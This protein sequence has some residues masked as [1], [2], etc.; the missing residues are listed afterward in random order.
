MKVI[1]EIPDDTQFID[2][3]LRDIK[4]T[5]KNDKISV[6]VKN[7]YRYFNVEDLEVYNKKDEIAILSEEK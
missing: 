3:I 7:E 5:Q 2:V 6:T 4:H 1:I